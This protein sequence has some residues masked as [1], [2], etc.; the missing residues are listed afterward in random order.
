MPKLVR[1]HL[2]IESPADW[3]RLKIRML[4]SHI[5]CFHFSYLS[6]S[7]NISFISSTRTRCFVYT[8]LHKCSSYMIWW[9]LFIFV[10]RLV[11]RNVCQISACVDVN[12]Y[13]VLF[14]NISLAYQIISFWGWYTVA[15]MTRS[16]CCIDGPAVCDVLAGIN[17]ITCMGE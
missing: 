15:I 14:V 7:T 5:L 12:I 3:S 8:T 2:Y 13:G 9:K 4:F 11:W 16:L 6:I 10:S 1:R 17:V